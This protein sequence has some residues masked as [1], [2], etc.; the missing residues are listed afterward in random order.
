M[1]RALIVSW[2]LKHLRNSSATGGT[3]YSDTSGGGNGTYL[4]AELDGATVDVQSVVDSIGS[5][6]G[7]ELKSQS[8]N[9]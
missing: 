6:Y 2:G 3:F 7:V 8:H 5:R 4:P 1:S 9:A